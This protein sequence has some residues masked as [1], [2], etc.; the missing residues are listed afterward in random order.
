MIPFLPI[1]LTA[2]V[3]ATLSVM[4]SHVPP[5]LAAPVIWQ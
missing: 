5:K 2:K 4:T 1:G 3:R